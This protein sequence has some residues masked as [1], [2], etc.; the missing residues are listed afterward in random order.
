[1]K[2]ASLLLLFFSTFFHCCTFAQPP[3]TTEIIR[4]PYIQNNTTSSALV[5][6]RT[7]LPTI[8]QVKYSNKLGRRG[9]I[10]TDNNLTTEHEITI[11]NLQI[12]T[13]YYY[14]I[15]SS[16]KVKLKDAKQYFKTNPAI[17][18][19]Q[20]IRIWAL[21]DFGCS[22]ATQIKVKDAIVNYTKDKPVDAWIWQGDNA[23]TYGKDDEFQKHVF[24]VYQDDFFKNTT[25]YPA[26]GN[27]D[28]A[29]KHDSSLPPYFKIF[30]MPANGEAGGVASGTE[31]Y[32]SVDFGNVHMISLNSE[33]KATDGTY[34]YDSTGT[35]A[36]WLIKDLEA[37]KL[38][39]VIAYWHKPSYSKGSHDSDTEDFMYKIR[40]GVNPIMEKYNVDLVIMGHSHV[41]ERTHPLRNHFGKDDTF[42]SK[43]HVF[44][45]SNS[46][47]EYIVKKGT[48]QGV[49]YIVNGSGGQLGGRQPGFPLNSAIYTNTEIGGSMIIDVEGKKMDAKWI[50]SDG[51]IMDKFTITKE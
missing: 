40:E 10:I 1:M 26:P 23:Y 33:E 13:K 30:N 2:T 7:N 49:I 31:A 36:K 9:K 18:S 45:S 28:Y 12:N 43:D 16:K 48:P 50:A 27:H 38:P 6:W 47:S 22:S 24:S 37:N 19:T 41:Y 20:P 42:S 21:G 29:G 46:T 17:G 3:Q 11:P 8:S 25:T 34:L 5:H 35:Q 14:K 15:T 4:G 51:S 32:Y 44:A 39:W